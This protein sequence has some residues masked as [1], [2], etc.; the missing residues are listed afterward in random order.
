MKVGISTS[1]I[2][3]GLS[4]V[5]QH[6]LALTRAFL[7]LEPRH[8]FTLFVLKE[9]LPLFDFARDRMELVAVPERHRPPVN[10]ILWHQLALPRL[11]RQRRLDVLHVPSYR[12][13]LA[14]RPC[15]LVA[16]IHDLA[17][18]RLAKKYDWKRM[19]YGKVVARRLARRQHELIVVSESTGRDVEKFFGIPKNRLHVIL[20]GL[21][22]S[23][24]FPG[25][26]DEAKG[27]IARTRGISQP[28]FL[29]I[30]RLEHPGKNHARLIEAFNQFKAATGSDWRLVLGGSDWH[31]ADVIHDCARKSPYASDIT[32][33][34]FVPDREIAT[35]YR[36]ADIFIYP[37][38]FEGFGMPPLEAMACACPV[39]CP[40]SGALGEVVGDAVANV[41]PED[42]ESLRTQMARLAGSMVERERLITRGLRRA[43]RF[44][45]ESAAVATLAVYQKA[46]IR[47]RSA[48][49][50]GLV[51]GELPRLP[52]RPAPLCPDSAPSD[53]KACWSHPPRSRVIP[54]KTLGSST[55]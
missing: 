20:N 22:H 43:P 33:L 48:G 16:T 36:G 50:A 2:Q 47:A 42:V 34:G 49:S 10:N 5:A 54:A 19:F 40:T 30:A 1:V 13:M 52:T 55:P 32:C 25:C 44:D 51:P 6:T 24:F 8:E 31:G 35:W 23:R 7:S 4:G 9:D 15:A 3:R 53:G 21:D 27:F 29:Y 11:A 46:V 37:S 18:F 41:N 28:F 45:W 17:P 39:I 12:R 14:T 38:L 26:R